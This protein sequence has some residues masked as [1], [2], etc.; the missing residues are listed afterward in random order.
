[1]NSR[2]APK[3]GTF[4]AQISNTEQVSELGI[5]SQTNRE[6]ETFYQC[7]WAPSWPSIYASVALRVLSIVLPIAF[8]GVF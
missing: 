2:D 5:Y 3:S 1:M 6:V 8:P 7:F 4:D